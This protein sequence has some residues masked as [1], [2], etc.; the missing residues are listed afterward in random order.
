[1]SRAVCDGCGILG[2]CMRGVCS[3]CRADGVVMRLRAPKRNDFKA[4]A[5]TTLP[6]PRATLDAGRE[7]ALAIRAE[8]PEGWA[9]VLGRS[10]GSSH[11]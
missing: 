1:M 3:M 4:W 10:P 6:I 7:R 5:A 8:D 2:A 11:T 9:E